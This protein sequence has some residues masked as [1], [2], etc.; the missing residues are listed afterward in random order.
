MKP[1]LDKKLCEKYPQIFQERHL[2]MSQTA[3]CWGFQC[4][5]G[6]FNLIDQL[7]SIIAWDIEHNGCPAVVATTVKEKYGTLRF[8]F[9]GGDERVDA[10]V[11]FAEQISGILC[12]K[13]GI[14]AVTKARNGWIAT[15][16]EQHAEDLGFTTLQQPPASYFSKE[17][18]NS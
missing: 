17:D 16:C 4:G 14:P 13:C 11:N 9:R 2:D 6:W 3:M 1:E 5:D 7:C 10:Y 15:L 18:E 12:E 8:Y